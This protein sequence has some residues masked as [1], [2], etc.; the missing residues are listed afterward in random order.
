MTENC[1]NNT[2]FHYILKSNN[3]NIIKIKKKN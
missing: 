3:K 1:K 2:H